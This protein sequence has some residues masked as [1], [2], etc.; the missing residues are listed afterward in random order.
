VSFTRAWDELAGRGPYATRG[1]ASH[2][3]ASPGLTFAP[4]HSTPPFRLELRQPL[5]PPPACHHVRAPYACAQAC[6]AGEQLPRQKAEHGPPCRSMLAGARSVTRGGSVALAPSYS[7]S[8]P[9]LLHNVAAQSM[10]DPLDPWPDQPNGGTV[11]LHL[12]L[13]LLL[14][15]CQ[16]G[17][18]PPLCSPRPPP[19]CDDREH[20][21]RTP[22]RAAVGRRA[23]MES[24]G[25]DASGLGT[26]H[27]VSH[28]APNCRTK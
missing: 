15:S 25:F 26:G 18:L 9:P 8:T 1:G 7:P 16:R 2:P 21:R 14:E 11:R 6:S 22:G 23:L 20:Q 19:L 27:P 24:A 3:R 28:S 12:H 5:L 17:E 4:R 10:T 13:Q